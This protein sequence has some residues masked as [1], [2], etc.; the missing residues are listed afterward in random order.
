MVDQNRSIRRSVGRVL[1]SLILIG[2]VSFGAA[3]VA[4]A[5]NDIGCGVGTELLKGREGVGFKILGS[6]TNGLTF[7]S[8]SITFGLLNCGK[9]N[10]ISAQIDH[11]TGSNFD[12]LA[13][14]MST[15]EGETLAA[16][17]TLFEIED[18]DRSRF[19]G[20]TQQNFWVLFPTDE[21][22]AGE[23]LSTLQQLMRDDARLS[24]YVAS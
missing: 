20:L 3:G 9:S 18:G 4:T 2:S 11:F 7:Q 22:T 23:M 6:F 15:G 10:T 12:R 8:I 13:A 16:L 14:E 19:Y 21:T 5:D 24:V 17:G 1:A